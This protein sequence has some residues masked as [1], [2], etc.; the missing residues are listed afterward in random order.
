MGAGAAA[1]AAGEGA[2]AGAGAGA[3]AEGVLSA[4]QADWHFE[5]VYT[6]RHS[7]LREIQ[8]AELPALKIVLQ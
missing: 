1:G 4:F 6:H 8:G 5:K 3:A 7:F 2:G